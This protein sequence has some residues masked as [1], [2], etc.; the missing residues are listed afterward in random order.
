MEE[1]EDLN[2]I[3]EHYEVLEQVGDGGQG[4]LFVGR[5]RKSG[6][7]VALK[8]QKE[9]E[10]ESENYFRDLAN[11]LDAEGTHARELARIPGIPNLFARGH[12][13]SRRCIVMEFVEG[14]LLFDLLASARPFKVATVASV[15]GQLCEILDAVHRSGLVHRDVKPENVM[16]EPDGR[17]RLLDL[18]LAIRA[19]KKTDR[20]CGTI[21]YAPPEQLDANPKG[22]TPQAD[23]FALGCMLLEMTVMQ[24]PYSGARRRA[25]QDCPV[26]P[27]ERLA[28]IPAEF[29][30][31]AL[32][33]VERELWR[34]P[35]DVREVFADLR[36]HLPS[37]GSRRP[38][39]PLRPDPTEYYRTRRPTL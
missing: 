35:V 2:E 6:R 16:V 24:L 8:I 12:Y 9:R 10:F 37:L 13:G 20:G 34:R 19:R 29:T 39:K 7:K 11:E 25:A 26:L 32:R 30:P 27:P 1:I 14:T 23:I 31:L 4:D 3:E 36:P 33:M 22:V 28:K 5:E 15:I 38:A 18:G 17:I 21:G